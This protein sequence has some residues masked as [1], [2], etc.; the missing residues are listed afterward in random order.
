MVNNYEH[1]CVRTVTKE[2]LLNQCKVLYLKHHPEL[3]HLKITADKI[4]FEVCKY[5]L[6]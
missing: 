6:E 4:V 2:M 5:Y 3:A 1:I